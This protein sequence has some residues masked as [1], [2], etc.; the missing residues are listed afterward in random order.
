MDI[1]VPLQKVSSVKG[2]LWIDFDEKLS[3]AADL[4]LDRY[5]VVARSENGRLFEVRSDRAGEFEFHLPQGRYAVFIQ[6]S[7]LSANI[8]MEDNL[9]SITVK[10]NEPIKLQPFRLKVRS[11]K[12]EIKRFG[13]GR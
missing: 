8:Y 2:Y 7:D 13:Q 11:K 12:I 1:A 4:S 5:T 3:V 6:E 9:Q 10:E